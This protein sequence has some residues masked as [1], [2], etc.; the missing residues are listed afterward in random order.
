VNKSRLSSVSW[1]EQTC[2]ERAPKK[3]SNMGC[4]LEDYWARAG[5][6]AAGSMWHGWARCVN[7]K[8]ATGTC[9]GLTILGS[10]VL[11][12]LLVIGGVELNPGSVAEVE[13]ITKL[14][15]TG[16]S[17]NLRS[18]TQCDLCGWWFHNNCGNVKT[19]MAGREKRIC[20]KCA[21]DRFIKQQEDLQNALRQI[22]ELKT[23]NNELDKKNY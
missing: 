8:R 20:A 3:G 2:L 15:C 14:T 9:L 19:Q 1:W 21:S 11:A 7:A 10:T 12:A 6:W 5:T 4:T 13:M 23:R 17:R 18:G 16:C 22:D